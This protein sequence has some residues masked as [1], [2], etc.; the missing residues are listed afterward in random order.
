MSFQP[1]IVKRAGRPTVVSA[2]CLDERFNPGEWLDRRQKQLACFTAI[3]GSYRRSAPVRGQWYSEDLHYFDL[4]LD[5]RPAQTRVRFT[6]RSRV[7]QAIGEVFF[8]PAGN[9]FAGESCEGSQR[10]L[11]LFLNTAP[12]HGDDW[13]RPV[14]KDG[15]SLAALHQCT[16]L[17]SGSIRRILHGIAREIYDPG[18]GS[19]VMLEGLGLML[20]GETARLLRDEQLSARRKG[21]LSPRASRLIRDRMMDGTT[22]PSIAE[23]ADLC[24]LSQRH[25]MR[26]F[27]EETGQTLG[28]FVQ[29]AAIERACQLLRTTDCPVSAVAHT[30]GFTNA[31]AFS[32]AFRRTTGETPRDYRQRHRAWRPSS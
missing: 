1:D 23:L 25:L 15:I 6:D 3:T 18:F 20:M 26:A 10:N 13:E 17:R 28:A 32:T 7:P 9:A 14:K 2:S 24:G 8:V 30:S 11:F 4:C 19:D 16:D 29:Q 12:S 21:G 27:R 22:L 31:A 5:V